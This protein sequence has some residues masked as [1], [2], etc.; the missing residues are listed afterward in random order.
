MFIIRACDF[1]WVCKSN[2]PTFLKVNWHTQFFWWG[3]V[4]DKHKVFKFS[5]KIIITYK[6]RS[7]LFRKSGIQIRNAFNQ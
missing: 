3:I 2:I 1:K 5:K 7:R 6:V 4:L